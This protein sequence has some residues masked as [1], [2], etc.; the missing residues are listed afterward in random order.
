MSDVLSAVGREEEKEEE[1]IL[2]AVTRNA[3]QRDKFTRGQPKKVDT[4]RFRRNVPRTYWKIIREFQ[5]ETQL[6]N[7]QK[8]SSKSITV[9]SAPLL[10][11][12]REEKRRFSPPG[13]SGMRDRDRR[14]KER[15]GLENR[16]RE[17]TAKRNAEIERRAREEESCREGLASAKA[18]SRFVTVR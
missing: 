5:E 13:G 14:G 16:W 4:A 17:V 8:S 1:G 2:S 7:G 12:F 11:E 18:G 6:E 10:P 3:N 9:R 15:R